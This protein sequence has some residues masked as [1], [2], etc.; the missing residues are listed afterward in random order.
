[1]PRVYKP[2]RAEKG[3]SMDDLLREIDKRIESHQKAHD[4]YQ[5]NAE[6]QRC[7]IDV[8]QSLR[9]HVQSQLEIEEKR[10]KRQQKTNP[11]TPTKG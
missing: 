11:E 3:Y 5:R 8:L 7:K 10:A 6:L 9:C 2:Q 4:D 1:M